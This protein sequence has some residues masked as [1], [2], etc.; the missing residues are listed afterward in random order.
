MLPAAETCGTHVRDYHVGAIVSTTTV[1][2]DRVSL[3]A[4]PRRASFDTRCQSRRVTVTVVV[5]CS[6]RATTLLGIARLLLL[7]AASRF[8]GGTLAA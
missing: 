6:N 5:V 1:F 4:T 3:L 7:F 8:T 2:D